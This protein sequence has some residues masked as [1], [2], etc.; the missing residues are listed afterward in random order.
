V[1]LL[2]SLPPGA[3]VLPPEEEP[4]AVSATS[5]RNAGRTRSFMALLHHPIRICGEAEQIQP[6]LRKFAC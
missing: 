4:Q 1:S 3:V 6:I 5:A 2:S